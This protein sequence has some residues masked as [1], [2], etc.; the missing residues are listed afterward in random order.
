MTLDPVGTRLGRRA[1]LR[2]RRRKRRLR[3]TGA[4]IA[5]IIVLLALVTVVLVKNGGGS[6]NKQATP[7]RTQRTLLLQIRAAD[8]TA[9]ASALLAHD[10]ASGMGAVVLIPQ[11][12]LA[13]VPGGGSVPFGK[14]LRTASVTASRNALADLMGVTIDGS[15]VLDGSTFSR[16]VDQVGQV[17]VTVDVPVMSGRTVLIQP[18]AQTLSGTAALQFATYL[19][20][21]E[22]EQTRLTRLQAVLDAMLNGLPGKPDTLLA[23]LGGGSQPTL[24]ISAVSSLLTGLKKDDDASN[25]QYRSLPVI[26]VD[27]GND[28]IRSRI[29]APATRSLVDDVLAQSIPPGSRTPGN[30]VLV[31][32]GVGTPGLGQ[33]VRD[34]LVPAGFVF[35]GS[36]NA[37]T[38]GHAK[39]Q[40]LVPDATT[41]A[42]ALGARV[43]RALGVPESSVQSSDQIG[44]I[45]DVVVIVGK[46]FTAK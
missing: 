18:G 7:D 21:S 31:L 14:A 16:L 12:V 6:G 34:K 46:D 36:S 33:K 4:A 13:T 26:K 2:E 3:L 15:W 17:K 20:P 35:V 45:A 19:G 8:G 44:T 11:Q 10:P 41:A 5:A 40:V 24:D 39:T 43:A 32:N 42:G 29:D 1:E 38:F 9:A 30:R 28:E 37:P 27:T 22:Q 23:S 25:L